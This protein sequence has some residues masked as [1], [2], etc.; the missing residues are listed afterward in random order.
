M[1]QKRREK[2]AVKKRTL[3]RPH[4][5]P[6]KVRKEDCEQDHTSETVW[7][8]PVQFTSSQQRH[9]GQ[10][11]SSSSSCGFKQESAF[12][13]LATH[14]LES[15]FKQESACLDLA[16]NSLESGVSKKVHAWIWR[17]T[18]LRVV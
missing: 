1:D 5:F 8:D 2:S 3:V 13:D 9:T 14:S 17:R 11:S 12:V 15:G 6:N 7:R 4:S 16:T 18:V 10:S